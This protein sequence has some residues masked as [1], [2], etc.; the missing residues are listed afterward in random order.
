MGAEDPKQPGDPD[1]GMLLVRGVGHAWMERVQ[2]VAVAEAG[3]EQLARRHGHPQL[4]VWLGERTERANR[5]T[6]EVGALEDRVDDG[7]ESGVRVDGRERLEVTVVSHLHRVGGDAVLDP[8]AF[9]PM[10]VV[11][12]DLGVELRRDLLS[13]EAKHV[14]RPQIGDRVAGEIGVDRCEIGR[15]TEHVVGRPL[16]LV[17]RPVARRMQGVDDGRER[18]IRNRPGEHTYSGLLRVAIIATRRISTC[19]PALLDRRAAA[20]DTSHEMIVASWWTPGAAAA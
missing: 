7:P 17:T 2:D 11:E 16:G 18:V 9:G 15:P 13:E 5:P 1:G 10:L 20:V 8:H 12:Q 6:I 4:V 19:T 3:G 14:L